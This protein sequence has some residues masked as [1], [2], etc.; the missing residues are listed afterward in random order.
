MFIEIEEIKREQHFLGNRNNIEYYKQLFP[1]KYDEIIE[2]RHNG[3]RIFGINYVKV[4]NIIN[5]RYIKTIH[6]KNTETDYYN[7]IIILQDNST[8]TVTNTYN[9]LAKQLIKDKE[10]DNNIVELEL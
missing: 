3:I 1:G 5:T 6:S 9:D 8:I 10:T 7:S 2:D 4:P